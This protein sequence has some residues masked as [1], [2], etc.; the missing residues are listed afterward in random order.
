MSPG[1]ITLIVL[2]SA[3]IAPVL[4]CVIIVGVFFSQVKMQHHISWKQ[5]RKNPVSSIPKEEFHMLTFGT[6]GPPHDQGLALG[7]QLAHMKTLYEPHVT[8]FRAFSPRDLPDRVTQSVGECDGSRFPQLAIHCRASKHHFWLWKSHAIRKRL[9]EIPQNHV[10]LY[11]DANYS[12]YPTQVQDP[13]QVRSATARLLELGQNQHIGTR[14][15]FTGVT[16]TQTCSPRMISRLPSMANMPNIT[17]DR[18]IVRNSVQGR[19]FIDRWLH[20]CEQEVLLFP[21]P[22]SN[23]NAKLLH[24]HDQSVFNYMAQIW[25]LEGKLPMTWPNSYLA[26]SRRF[27][28][29]NI[30]AGPPPVS[31]MPLVRVLESA[32]KTFKMPKVGY[33]KHCEH[34]KATSKNS[35]GTHKKQNLH[36][37]PILTDG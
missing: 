37:Q 21:D 32:R 34:Y 1:S 36:N 30:I 5:H 17:I 20:A 9:S 14:F 33:F 25:R 23:G 31:F 15:S 26:L 24:L 16:C 35:M 10:L 22:S 29:K 7:E 18:I 8:T 11:T 12:K 2:V 3:S 4:V 28:E 6:L 13:E 19:Q 27:A